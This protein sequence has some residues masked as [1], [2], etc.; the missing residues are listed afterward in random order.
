MNII[1]FI[2]CG[3]NKGSMCV[4][5]ANI[6]ARVFR[7]HPIFFWCFQEHQASFKE[8]LEDRIHLK[9]IESLLKDP[10]GRFPR[11][12]GGKVRAELSDVVRVLMLQQAYSAAKDIVCLL[13]LYNHG[14]YYL[15]TT[16]SIVGSA[17]MSA[18]S[19][20]VEDFKQK[21]NTL[22]TRSYTEPRFAWM[23]N[24]NGNGWNKRPIPG[25]QTGLSVVGGALSYRAESPELLMDAPIIDVWAAYSPA[26]DR[27]TELMVLS[28]LSRANRLGINSS[29]KPINFD[30]WNG[31][32]E[33]AKRGKN[34]LRNDIIGELVIGA[35]MDGLL[36]ATEGEAEPVL[37][38]AWDAFDG[39]EKWRFP[40][41]GLVCVPELGI[42][43]EYKNSWRN[44]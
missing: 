32:D 40:P 1:H 11:A 22:L 15:D 23:R 31:P 25:L 3:P 16:T 12:Q 42:V 41:D 37:R 27:R 35:V 34:S 43:K 2:W 38:F 39:W 13:A 33:L 29:G 26:G 10:L 17:G 8:D 9:T 14:G 36:D 21:E 4:D 6:A 28:Y 18:F 20:Q 24:R 30:G 5:T 19:S 7:T 44:V